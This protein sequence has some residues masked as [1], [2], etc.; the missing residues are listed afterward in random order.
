MTTRVWWQTVGAVL[1]AVLLALAIRYILIR[2][3]TVLVLFS[4]GLLV[5]WVMDPLLDALQKRGWHRLVAVWAVMIGILVLIAITGILIVPGLVSQ[6]QDAANHWQ[7][8][9]NTAQ[10]TYH[11]WRQ[12]IAQYSATKLPNVE[13]M[14]FLDAK[15]DQATEWLSSNIPGALQW[16]S[17]QLIASIGLIAMGGILLI[18]SFHF[19]NIIDPLRQSIRKM[20]P[21]RTDCEVNRLG[22]QINAMLAQYLRGIVIISVL[23][24]IS[25]TIALYIVSIFFGTKYALILGVITG[26][27]YMIP[28]LGPLLSALS[29]G[30][31]GYVTA[32]QSPWLACGVSVAAMYAVN[33]VYD[34]ALTP[35]IVGQRVG[36]HPLVMLLSVFLGV[37]LLG[38]PGMIIATP[39]AASIKI[40]LARWLP[41]KEMDFTAPCPKRRLDIDMPASVNLLAQTI[42]RVGRD[43]E[44]SMHA[45]QAAEQPE[46]QEQLPLDEVTKPKQEPKPKP[47][48]DSDKDTDRDNA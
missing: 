10:Q 29:A 27:T 2:T 6:I 46:G 4:L 19:M 39:L 12:S 13:V 17:Q 45:Q 44:R 5:A 22:G 33:Q 43:L 40:V 34:M 42:V 21:E 36:L 38:I 1:V 37:S 41:I 47:D 9:S 14:P 25:A 24:G 16:L 28:Y 30:F 31:F 35:R 11:Q 7:D 32:A 23:V 18:I 3:I 26:V 48:T 20:L 8:Y 15:V